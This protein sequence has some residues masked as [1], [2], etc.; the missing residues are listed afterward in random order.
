MADAANT[1]Y[2]LV[3]STDLDIPVEDPEETIISNPVL[4]DARKALLLQSL[5]VERKLLDVD[6]KLTE[7]EDIIR[8]TWAS[9]KT[10]HCRSLLEWATALKSAK[11]LG[12][13]LYSCDDP[14]MRNIGFVDHVTN[15]VFFLGLTRIHEATSEAWAAS[16]MTRDD[17]RTSS[18]RTRMMEGDPFF[19]YQWDR[20]AITLEEVA[21]LQE[22]VDE[23]CADID[24][25]FAQ[26]VPVLDF[27]IPRPPPR[28]VPS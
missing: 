23:M 7:A 26:E 27:L 6:G 17:F 16:G 19:E 28:A 14:K 24:R 21:H 15:E 4:D 25:E 1:R 13:E 5:V 12:H 9:M 10:T 20:P 18:M 3:H 2:L 8:E 22:L 11:E